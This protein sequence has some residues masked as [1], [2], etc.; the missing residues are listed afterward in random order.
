MMA[1]EQQRPS[2]PAE[3]RVPDDGAAAAAAAADDDSASPPDLYRGLDEDALRAKSDQYL[4]Q[5]A[6]DF[7]RDIIAGARGLYIYTLSGRPVLDWT[8][9]QMSCLLGHGHPE[10][11]S[12]VA[13][14]A[15]QLDHLCSSMLSPPVLA[16]AERLCRALPAGLDRAFFLSTGA[17]SNEAAMRLAKVCTGRFEIVGVGA[18][19]TSAAPATGR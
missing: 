7:H 13:E 14:H 8:S 12:V 6:G 5:Y 4:L 9:G 10:V 18:S 11:A 15:R 3:A 19:T 17:E 2:P 16:L 1:T